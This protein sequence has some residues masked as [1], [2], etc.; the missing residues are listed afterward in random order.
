MEVYHNTNVDDK[1]IS[2]KLQQ[3]LAININQE[4]IN[5]LLQA[6]KEGLLAFSVTVGLNVI[7][8]MMEE[9][10]PQHVGPKGKHNSEHKAYRHGKEQG[11]GQVVLGVRKVKIKHPRVQTIGGKELVWQT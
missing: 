6:V 2:P 3:Q 10:V 4:Q 7:K 11:Q 9:E 1:N 5:D 8:T